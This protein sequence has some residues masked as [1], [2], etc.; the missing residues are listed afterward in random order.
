MQVWNSDGSILTGSWTGATTNDSLMGGTSGGFADY[1]CGYPNHIY[2]LATDWKIR[3]FF[4]DRT[5]GDMSNW[6][7]YSCYTG[8]VTTDTSIAAGADTA[9]AGTDGRVWLATDTRS[10]NNNNYWAN[11]TS[12]FANVLSSACV[13]AWNT[14]NSNHT[15]GSAS[16]GHQQVNCSS[17]ST[18]WSA[19]AYHFSHPAQGVYGLEILYDRNANT[20][21]MRH[22]TDTGFTTFATTGYATF[23]NVPTTGRFIH[24]IGCGGSQGSYSNYWSTTYNGVADA[25]KGY[26]INASN[27]AAGTVTGIANVPTT[28]NQTEVSGVMLYKD[29]AGTNTI[30]GG[31]YDLKI[32][33]TCDG[34]SNWTEAAGYTAVTPLF[35]TGVKMVKLAKTTCTA[36]NDV[37]Y[38]AVF[39]NQA[40]GSLEARLYGIA[41]NY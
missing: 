41:L 34:G 21:T 17:G 1:C 22:M 4:V 16:V 40:S 18:P 36:G 3:I 30:G 11:S 31:S 39:A 27:N 28:T 13:T 19:S 5:T 23:S 38:R 2:D 9:S 15:Y 6:E 20:I 35:S 7:T 33:F 8:L 32:E 37:R 29:Q 24:W 14:A 10:G 26:V 25:F 12:R